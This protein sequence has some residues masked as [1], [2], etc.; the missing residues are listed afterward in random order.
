MRQWGT[1]D[2]RWCWEAP[3]RPGGGWWSGC[4]RA[5]CRLHQLHHYHP[6]TP[7]STTYPPFLPS[8]VGSGHCPSHLPL[9]SLR[10][11]TAATFVVAQERSHYSTLLY[12][13]L[14]LLTMLLSTPPALSLA[15][16]SPRSTA[17]DFDSTCTAVRIQY[18]Y[19]TSLFLFYS[20]SSH[21]ALYDRRSPLTSY[22]PISLDATPF[23][24]AE[25]RAYG[26]RLAALLAGRFPPDWRAACGD[27]FSAG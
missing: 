6:L 16:C 24:A 10:C 27:G 17:L 2:T 21:Q 13:L 1:S 26:C 3:A 15:C 8:P 7:P 18:L 20:D 9:C 4:W 19:N 23:P 22:K 5:G 12:R 25:L 14:A 11:T